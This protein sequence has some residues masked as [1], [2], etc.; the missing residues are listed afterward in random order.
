MDSAELI[1]C[2]FALF[3][4]VVVFLRIVGKEKAHQERVIQIKQ[5]R[6]EREAQAKALHERLQAENEGVVVTA[7]SV[8]RAGGMEASLGPRH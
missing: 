8:Q 4:A 1:G 2:G 6:A 7:D 3:V 5:L